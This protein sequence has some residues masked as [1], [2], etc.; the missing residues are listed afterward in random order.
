MLT[1]NVLSNWQEEKQ[2]LVAKRGNEI[3]TTIA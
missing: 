1:I 2:D 3:I